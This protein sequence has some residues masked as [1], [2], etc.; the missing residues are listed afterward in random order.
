MR[1]SSLYLGFNGIGKLII[2]IAV[3]LAILTGLK[4]TKSEDKPEV[5]QIVIQK[6]SGCKEGVINHSVAIVFPIKAIVWCH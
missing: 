6:K 1:L 5:E 3:V 4:R 2:A